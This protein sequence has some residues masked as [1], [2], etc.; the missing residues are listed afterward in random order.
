[1][2][3]RYHVALRLLRECHTDKCTGACQCRQRLPSFG[4]STA[5]NNNATIDGI[6]D[7]VDLRLVQVRM[8]YT[9]LLTY[10]MVQSPS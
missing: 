1:M 5:S 3:A 10:S 7:E 2:A 4:P 9:Y 8:K 6:G